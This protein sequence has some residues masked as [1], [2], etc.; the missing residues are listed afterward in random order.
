MENANEAIYL[1]I[2]NMIFVIALSLTIFLFSS[3]IE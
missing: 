1:G 3:L 2:Y